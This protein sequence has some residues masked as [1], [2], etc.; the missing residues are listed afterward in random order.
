[1]FYLSPLSDHE[2]LTPESDHAL[3]PQCFQD[4][5]E[6]TNDCGMSRLLNE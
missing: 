4:V 2:L 3:L 5:T 6:A 1:M